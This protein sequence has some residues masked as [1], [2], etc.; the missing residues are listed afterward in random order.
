MRLRPIKRDFFRATTTTIV[1]TPKIRP[2]RGSLRSDGAQGSL[3]RNPRRYLRGIV[4]RLDMLPMQAG[5]ERRCR[6]QGRRQVKPRDIIIVESLKE[7]KGKEEIDPLHP[8]HRVK[9]KPA[10]AELEFFPG[11]ILRLRDRGSSPLRGARASP[12]LQPSY[13]ELALPSRK[14]TQRRGGCHKGGKLVET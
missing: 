5:E 13:E 6:P 3:S 9:S 8:L 11:N 7:H 12:R 1:C 4:A 2:T 10:Q 14:Q